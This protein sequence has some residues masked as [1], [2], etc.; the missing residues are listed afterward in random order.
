MISIQVSGELIPDLAK[1]GIFVLE[2]LSQNPT[3]GEAESDSEENY[4]ASEELLLE[5]QKKLDQIHALNVTYWNSFFF[6]YVFDGVTGEDIYIRLADDIVQGEHEER[7]LH[8]L[9][10]LSCL[11]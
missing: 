5:V 4:I 7:F 8:R 2:G 3:N 10:Y 11:C 9:M 1:A 6:E